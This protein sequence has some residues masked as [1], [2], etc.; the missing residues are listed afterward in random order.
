MR[1]ENLL[2]LL[3][4]QSFY[5]FVKLSIS[6]QVNLLR[7]DG[8]FLDQDSEKEGITCLYFL[9]G[10]FVE[11]VFGGEASEIQDIIPYKQGYRISMLI[12]ASRKHSATHKTTIECCAN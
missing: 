10:F 5:D 7:K 1:T 4:I 3:N 9:Q 12:N 2:P 8:V 11:V 6:E